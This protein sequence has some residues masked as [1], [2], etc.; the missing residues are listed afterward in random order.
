MRKVTRI[1]RQWIS[2]SSCFTL[3]SIK[4]HPWCLVIAAKWQ[5]PT[6]ACTLL[7]LLLFETRGGYVYIRVFIVLIQ[8]ND[9]E[10]L[11]LLSHL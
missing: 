1:L 2:I 6:I 8:M 11:Y 5:L 7:S 9:R 4:L 3:Y 10:M